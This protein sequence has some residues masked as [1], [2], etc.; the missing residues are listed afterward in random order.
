MKI[1]VSIGYTCHNRHFWTLSS[2]AFL[3]Y[4]ARC[5]VSFS[6]HSAMQTWQGVTKCSKMGITGPILMILVPMSTN[7]RSVSSIMERKIIFFCLLHSQFKPQIWPFLAKYGHFG[8][9]SGTII[10]R[11]EWYSTNFFIKFELSD[12]DLV[13]IGTKIIK[14][15]PE[16]PILE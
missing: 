12:L 6:F 8:H 5:F 2:R 4:I 9:I 16:M 1:P 14:I 13:E 15:V 11:E 7:L 3:L 10:D